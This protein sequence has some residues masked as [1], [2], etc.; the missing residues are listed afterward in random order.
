MTR[1][2]FSRPIDGGAVSVPAPV[3]SLTVVADTVNGPP[4]TTSGRASF[5]SPLPKNSV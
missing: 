4:V 5:G 2:Q 1:A 3:S